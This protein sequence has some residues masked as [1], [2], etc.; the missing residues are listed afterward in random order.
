[1]SADNHHEKNII[2]L[3]GRLV[4]RTFGQRSKSEHLGVYLVTDQGDYLIRPAGANPFMDNPLMKMAGKTVTAEG[5]I[6]DYV[7]LARS[8]KEEDPH[9][10]AAI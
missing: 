9:T 8:W 7:F 5:Y 1:M 6:V 2:R 4:L 3:T 10:D